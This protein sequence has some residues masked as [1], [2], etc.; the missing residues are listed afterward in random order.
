MIQWRHGLAT[1]VLVLAIALMVQAD[2]LFQDRFSN[3]DSGW[4]EGTQFRAAD[5]AYT[6]D[7]EYRVLV[8]D[9]QRIAWSKAPMVNPV[10]DFC[11][12]VDMRQLMNPG[13]ATKGEIGVYYGQRTA[14]ARSFVT[15][16]FQSNGFL[17]VLDTDVEDGLTWSDVLPDEELDRI[18]NLGIVNEAPSNNHLRI[19]ASDGAVEIFV[20]GELA[21]EYAENIIEGFLG[22][23]SWSFD[24]P[25]LNARFDNFVLTT[26]DCQA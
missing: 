25:N 23:Y 22:M 4:F 9:D 10:R 6:D 26:P 18:F 1:T 13:L 19:I 24:E 20:N 15:V 8:T 5:W 21:V 2:V 3:P 16:G 17:T 7:G 14:T 12:D 11:L